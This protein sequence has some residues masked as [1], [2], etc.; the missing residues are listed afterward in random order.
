M[1]LAF[2]HDRDVE[3]ADTMCTG[4]KILNKEN[5]NVNFMKTD[6]NST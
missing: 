3:N 5:T 6:A 2:F 1:T 4:S